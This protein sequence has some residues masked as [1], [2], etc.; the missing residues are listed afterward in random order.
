MPV[1]RLGRASHAVPVL[2]GLLF[3]VLS[4][5]A[6]AVAQE[7]IAE[8]D[9][10]TG[11]TVRHVNEGNLPQAETVAREALRFSKQALPDPSLELATAHNNLGSVLSFQQKYD[12]AVT[13]HQAALAQRRQLLPPA[14]PLITTSLENLADTYRRMGRYA[15]AVPHFSEALQ[16]HVKRHGETSPQLIAPL[17]GLAYALTFQ[18][19]RSAADTRRAF[20]LFARVMDLR[21]A[22]QTEMNEGFLSDLDKAGALAGEIEL[23]DQARRFQERYVEAATSLYGP[24]HETTALAHSKLATTLS[25]LKDYPAAED[26]YAKAIELSTRAE[27]RLSAA[28]ATYHYRYGDHLAGRGEYDRAE[29]AYRETLDIERQIFGEAHAETI[30]SYNT[31][32]LL[33]YNSGKTSAAEKLLQRARALSGEVHGTDSLWYATT[34]D[35]LALAIAGLG[36]AEDAIPLHRQALDI[37]QR[38]LGRNHADTSR[39][40]NNLALALRSTGKNAE[41]EALFREALRID[42]ETLAPDDYA[43]AI[44]LGNLAS[45][46]EAKWD[47]PA[48]MEAAP[49]YAEALGIARANHPSTHPN[50][51]HAI[52]SFANVV[53]RVN[54]L[55]QGTPLQQQAAQLMAQGSDLYR[56]AVA[57]LSA[58]VNR[59]AIQDNAALFQTAAAQMLLVSPGN[60]GE[61]FVAAQW[62]LQSAASRAIA[63]TSLRVSS[64]DD[65]L[66]QL[67]RRQQDRTEQ[68]GQLNQR[69][70]Q[71]LAE[72]D[73]AAIGVLRANLRRLEDEITQLSET[74]TARFPAYAEY[75]G[76]EPASGKDVAALLEDDEALVLI[77]PGFSQSSGDDIEGSVFVVDAN[78]SVTSALLEAGGGLQ[79]DA[80]RLFCSLRHGAGNC[81]EPGGGS[82]NTRGVLS[83]D[84]SPQP[85][86]V[87]TFDMELAHSLFERIFA[88]VS[89][90][91]SKRK[92]LIIVSAD[93]ALAT[94]PFQLLLTKPHA[95]AQ[96][97]QDYRDA[98]WLIRDWAISVSTSVSAFTASRSQPGRVTGDGRKPFLGFGDPLIGAAAEI[99]CNAVAPIQIAS[100][101]RGV[102]DVATN[103][104]F[105]DAAGTTRIA[106]VD[107]VRRLARLPDTRCELEHIAS[108]LG[109]GD[110]FLTTEATEARVK[111]MNAQGVLSE[112]G[113]ISFATHGL[114]AGE[115]SLSEPALVLTPPDEGSIRDDGLLTASEVAALELDADWVLLSA[116]NTAAGTIET[117]SGDRISESFSGLARAFFYA[118]AKSLLVSHWPVQSEA[119]VRLTTR[120]FQILRAQPDID[121]ASAFRLAMLAII[122]DPNGTEQTAH[123]EYWAPFTLLGDSR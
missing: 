73:A 36:Q 8:W 49:M 45:V 30:N 57:I 80:E 56:E 65:A 100:L 108:S 20:D 111:Q 35:N 28:T 98:P 103:A 118:G 110:L 24:A 79:R 58:P 74:I 66:G 60:A 96:G 52:D 54:R 40:I 114:V 9:R 19:P 46:L 31:L 64:G 77:N 41:A 25:A 43:I 119:A 50:I 122:D 39:T 88:P 42:R 37:R 15:D 90:A 32:G 1:R 7:A 76:G 123:P 102:V 69:I 12:E 115:T 116:C 55:A 26:A 44:A 117:N 18:D 81:R 34:T 27:G 16:H 61:A 106:D 109:G 72:K 33:L 59:D 38:A 104:L 48:L 3:L 51:A 97:Q 23:P 11:E 84:E 95:G 21:D 101:S 29:R 105:S 47:L 4:A 120:T 17:R 85:S 22:A 99:D 91:L 75:R 89:G 5:S 71:S 63:A 62:P 86:S 93:E 82:D 6:Q 14:D 87:V 92:K 107:A 112:Y 83:L 53:M 68:H 70:L 67:L 113:T 121:R 2:A 94:L 78:G 10:L 13:E